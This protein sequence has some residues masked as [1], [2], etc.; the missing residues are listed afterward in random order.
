MSNIVA[1]SQG[2]SL[3]SLAEIERAAEM[4]AKSGLFGIKSKEQA[5]TLMM[6][7][8]SE[9]THIMNAMR[10]F[11]VIDGKPSLKA[12]AILARFQAAG[13]TVKWLERTDAA[14]K[15]KFSHPQGGEIEVEWTREAAEKAGFTWAYV[16]EWDNADRKYKHKYDA[17]GNKIKETKE[18]WLK[19]PRQML[20]ARV[21]SEGVRTIYPKCLNGF[22]TP[23]EVQDFDDAKEPLKAEHEVVGEPAAAEPAKE[24]NPCKINLG[25]DTPPV[26]PPPPPATSNMPRHVK[27]FGSWAAT[28]PDPAKAKAIIGKY[29]PNGKIS[30]LGFKQLNG[31]AMELAGAFDTFAPVFE[32]DDGGY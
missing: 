13:G 26:P 7:A 5:A 8:Q 12:D 10:E 23:E 16:K 30:T 27:E 11:H 3:V 21:I 4:V 1:A 32:F 19:I 29:C 24:P 9:G 17:S 31:M 6:V 28:L 15:A 2:G 22:Y 14:C 18:N 20:T 25:G